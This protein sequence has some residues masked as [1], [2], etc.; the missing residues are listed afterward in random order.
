MG[1]D[2]LDR[3]EAQVGVVLVVDRVELVALYEAHQVRELQGED[4]AGR[5]QGLHP[6]HEVVEIGDVR[7]HVVADQQI[8][9]SALRDHLAGS[10]APEEGHQG[11]DALLLR[12][13]RAV[14]RRIDPEHR[15]P[16]LEEELEEVAVVA[17]D[18]RHQASGIEPEAPDHLLRVAPRVGEPGIGV[19][20][21]VGVVAGPE[22]DVGRHDLLDL[23]QEAALTDPHVQRVEGLHLPQLLGPHVPLAERRGPQVHEGVAELLPAEA[24]SRCQAEILAFAGGW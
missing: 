12:G 13:P 19:G 23:H 9:R 24:T 17:G 1:E 11:V 7:E 20:G 2:L 3:R 18:L 22:E 10:F 16:L 5:E 14:R 15:D 21:E 8:G 6:G 4:A